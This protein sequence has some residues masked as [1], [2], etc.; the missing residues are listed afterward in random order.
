M[1]ATGRLPGQPRRPPGDAAR[2]RRLYAV[3][4]DELF[5]HEDCGRTHPLREHRDCRAARP[6]RIPGQGGS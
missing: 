2:S 1:T 3:L 5:W 6:S 4:K